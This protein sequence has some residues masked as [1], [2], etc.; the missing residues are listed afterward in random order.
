MLCL[1]KVKEEAGWVDLLLLDRAEIVFA[2]NVATRRLMLPDNLVIKEIAQ[3]VV[4]K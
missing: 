1:I 3:S 2:Q 4:Q